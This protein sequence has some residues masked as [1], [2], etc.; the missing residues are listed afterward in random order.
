MN[1]R[2]RIGGEHPLFKSGKSIDALG[3]VLLNSKVFGDGKGKREHRVV[4]EQLIGRPLLSG[5]IVH[6]VN[7]DKTDNR[8]ENLSIE[9]RASHNR[10]HGKGGLMACAKCG[11]QKWYS[12]ALMA[13]LTANIYMC[14]NCR[15]GRDWHNGAKG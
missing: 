6:H 12:P 13:R 14:R 4:M 5:E 7:G 1:K 15:Y 9:S 10:E 2:N 8:P 11:K 3:Y